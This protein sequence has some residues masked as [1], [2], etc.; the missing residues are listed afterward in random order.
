MHCQSDLN[1]IKDPKV[2]IVIGSLSKRDFTIFGGC[3]EFEIMG[4]Y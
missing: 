2:G 1:G 4:A 3:G